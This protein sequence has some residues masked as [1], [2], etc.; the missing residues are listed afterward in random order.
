M[1]QEKQLERL[2]WKISRLN[3][4]YRPFLIDDRIYPDVTI[5]ERGSTRPARKGE[6]WGGEFRC[7]EFGFTVPALDGAKKYY[8]SADTGAVEHLIRVNGRAVGLTDHIEGASE[9]QFRVHRYVLLDGLKTGDRV[10][11]EGYYSHT[12]PGTMP[13]DRKH[14][15]ALTDYLPDRPYRSISLVTF[16]DTLLDFC[17]KADWF[18]SYYRSLP[19]DGFARAAAAEVYVRLFGVL[20]MKQERPTEQ[21]LIQAIEII[22]QFT[23]GLPKP[24]ERPY[25]GIIGHSHLDTAWLWTV[26]ETRRKLH[27]TVSNAVTL[28]K[29]HPDYRFFLSTVL[30]LDW[31]KQDDPQLFDEVK[32]LIREGRIEPNGATWVECDC[33]LTGAEA[34]CRQ[35]LR[36]QRYLRENFGYSADTFWLPDTFGYSAA[37]PQIM[38]QCGVKNFLTTKLSWNDTNTFPYRS[39][40]WMGIDGSDVTVHFNTIQSRVDP[41]S[42][43]N[44]IASLPNKREGDCALIAYGFGDGGGGP[45][46]EMVRSAVRTSDAYPGARVEHTTVS[47]FMERLARCDLPSYYGE[48]YLEL[49]RGTLTTNHEIKRCN[50]RL[51]EGL[52]NAEL[53]TVFDRDADKKS[54]TDRLYDVLLLNQFH[55][56]LPG[57][58]IAEV[59]DVAVRQLHAAISDT[60]K[61][62]AGKGRKKY[63]NTLP[64][65]RRELLKHPQGQEYPNLKGERLRLAPYRF[66]PFSYGSADLQA[67]AKF[68]FDGKRITTPLLT[69][70]LQDGVLHSLVYKGSE[71]AGNGLNDITVSEDVPYIYDNWDF[72]ADYKLKEKHIPCTDTQL[73]TIGDYFMIIRCSY[74]ISDRSSLQ[75]DIIFFADSP[76]I[77]FANRL[78]FHDDHLLVRA[79]FDSALFSPVWHGETQ[80]GTLTRNCYPRN[81]TDAAQFEVC[82]HKWVDLSEKNRGL[83]LL[84]DS[85]YGYSCTGST[86]GLTLLKSGTHPD[87][88]ADNGTHYFRYALLPHEGD[89]GMDTVSAAYCFNNRPVKTARRIRPIFQPANQNSVIA[90]TVKFA[91]DKGVIIR[92]YECLGCSAET[93]MVFDRPYDLTLCNILEDE[94]I[95]LPHG[96]SVKL[97]FR[98]FEIKTLKIQ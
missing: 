25:V 94:Q 62:V 2:I 87:A 30:Y 20:S 97:S 16:Y 4:V 96:N 80:F 41:E 76:Q 70:E 67:K 72:D 82:A 34:L 35:F 28:L 83:S 58:S 50:R 10:S 63:Y 95:S 75:T 81:V 68:S 24:P 61:I 14:T 88:R 6:K 7:A 77:E 23:E 89:L 8:L 44:R 31:L 45:S 73:V 22:D 60:E 19:A 78:D 65:P 26:D 38:R 51:E 39:F 32:D 49:H 21:S 79:N 29:R 46:D 3:E 5:T 91:E 59:N 52:H 15:F 98:P 37:L 42:V 56:I 84:S 85:K 43:A 36:G 93:E 54:E 64:F 17:E 33:N 57:T 53:I 1:L 11:L 27:R 47:A 90:E 13:Y 12:I 48:L 86:I 40:R 74:R 66:E 9:E 18:H 69:A 71:F 92:L 55:D